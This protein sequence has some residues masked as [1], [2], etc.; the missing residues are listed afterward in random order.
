MRP[1][2]QEWTS[3]CAVDA[4]PILGARVI[5]RLSGGNVAVFRTEESKVFALLDSCP[6]KGG[7]LSQGIVYGERVACPLHNWQIG[8]ADGCAQ[9]PDTG[10]TVRFDTR[11]EGGQVLMKRSD[12]HAVGEA[13]ALAA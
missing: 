9:A 2:D 13:Q 6:H 12:L 5:Q 11:V 7:P 4:V 8:L 10:C 1:K 3:V